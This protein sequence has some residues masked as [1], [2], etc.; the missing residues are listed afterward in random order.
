MLRIT[1]TDS[2]E[3]VILKLEGKLAGPWVEEFERC[4]RISTDIYKEKGLVVD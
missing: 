1:T 2:G 3:K 4:W